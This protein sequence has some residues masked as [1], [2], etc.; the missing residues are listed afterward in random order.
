MTKEICIIGNG[1]IGSSV[2]KHLIKNGYKVTCV[3]RNEPDVNTRLIDCKYEIGLYQNLNSQFYKGFDTIVLTAG[4]TSQENS[5]NLLKVVYND[6]LGYSYLVEITKSKLIYMSSA[7]IYGNTNGE[8]VIETNVSVNGNYYVMGKVVR[9]AICNIEKDKRIYGLILGTVAGESPRV[10][11]DLIIN[12][13]VRDA[14]EDKEITIARENINRSIIGMNDLCR[15]IERII[16]KGN[17]DNRGVYNIASFDTDV[18]SIRDVICNKF[19]CEVRYKDIKSNYSFHICTDKFI[20]KFDFTFQ[21]TMEDI[22]E[23]MNE[24]DVKES[25]IC[26]VCDKVTNELLYLGEQPL[27]NEYKKEYDTESK[28]YPLCLDYCKECFHVQLRHTVN[29]RILFDKYL[30]TS[31]TSKTSREYF[32]KFAKDVI[33]RHYE[34]FGKTKKI[35][36]LDIACND[37]S[38]LDEFKLLDVTTVG[39]DPA[40]NLYEKSRN[41]GHEIYCEYFDKNC[42]EKLLEKHGKFDIIIAQNVFAHVDDPETFLENCDMIMD[43]VLYIQTSQANM[44]T[45]GEYDTVY[46]EHLSFFNTYSMNELCNRAEVVLNRVDITDIH[47]SS[48]KFEITREKTKDTNTV[49]KIYEEMDEKLYDDRTYKKY[50]IRC[51]IYNNELKNTL[52]RYK[53]NDYRIIGFG[54]TAKFN[55]VL[56]YANIT[57]DT[58]DYIIDENELKQGLYTPGSNIIIESIDK[59]HTIVDKTVIIISAWN[60]YNEIKQ[61]IMKNCKN[62]HCVKL[63]NINPIEE[64]KIY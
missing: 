51:N 1:Y 53:L 40:R 41:K 31:G 58:I 16:E 35:K 46:H 8:R 49:D 14:K 39:V 38:Q 48:Y 22:I 43:K 32:K 56:N 61:K 13:L 59:L 9:D 11:Y 4:Q 18:H 57:S 7:A 10:R 36:V 45:N 26:K 62:K 60:F 12:K 15:V 52:L 44:I 42:A 2:I 30:Y 19:K 54:S 17:I 47:G 20:N 50:N 33:D 29:K 28:K 55:T 27:A 64:D 6:I 5:K 21:D 3:T 63:L 25:R 34:I 24:E 37:G 23:T